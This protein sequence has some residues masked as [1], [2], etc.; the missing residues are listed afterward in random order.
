[1]KNNVLSFQFLLC[2]FFSSLTSGVLGLDLAQ[3]SLVAPSSAS[4]AAGA[5]LPEGHLY[6][7]FT[8]LGQQPSLVIQAVPQTGHPSHTPT[9]PNELNQSL[10]LIKRSLPNG[11]ALVGQEL[12]VPAPRNTLMSMSLATQNA[13]EPE[14]IDV[15]N[16]APN[17]KLDL[18]QVGRQRDS[19]NDWVFTE[20]H[21]VSRFNLS[22]LCDRSNGECRI[23]AAGFSREGTGV[24][25][26]PDAQNFRYRDAEGSEQ[27]DAVPTAPVYV[28]S[29]SGALSTLTV[30]GNL[31][32]SRSPG[33]P[34]GNLI[35]RDSETHQPIRHGN[36]LE[37][38]TTLMVGSNIVLR[39][40]SPSQWLAIARDR[41]LAHTER[42]ERKLFLKGYF[43]A[44]RGECPV[45]LDTLRYPSV[46]Q[47][48]TC[49]S[50]LDRPLPRAL[51]DGAVSYRP[52]VFIHCGHVVAFTDENAALRE[53][54]MCRGPRPLKRLLLNSNETVDTG[55]PTH[56]LP[57]GHAISEGFLNVWTGLLDQKPAD[58]FRTQFCPFDGVRFHDQPMGRRL[59][60]PARLQEPAAPAPEEPSTMTVD[61]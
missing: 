44:Q 8:V 3:A 22:V 28:V 59:Y 11:R 37:E 29:P 39:W 38:G 40:H 45:L 4:A 46:S 30:R 55:E 14:R 26:G 27:A 9:L 36:L 12:N 60:Y 57:C 48:L 24:F 50:P 17:L 20:N 61:E 25:L 16:F 33:I 23:Y 35:V 1:M 34:L 41:E 31:L 32:A 52:G 7:A 21:F 15:L 5:E 54:P 6:G 43:N 53:C 2:A 49:R 56:F 18:F 13:G 47:E 51:P 10:V 19:N 42:R 58:G